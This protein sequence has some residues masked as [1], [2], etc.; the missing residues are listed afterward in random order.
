MKHLPTPVHVLLEAVFIRSWENLDDATKAQYILSDHRYYANY[1]HSIDQGD[2]LYNDL[3]THG[4]H[5]IN[6]MLCADYPDSPE[7]TELLDL[8]C[9]AIID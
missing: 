5:K 8:H 3:T 6:P 1:C 2:N 4:L 7:L 9:Y